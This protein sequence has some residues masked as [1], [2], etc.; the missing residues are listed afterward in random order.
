[1]LLE[2][3]KKYVPKE[4]PEPQDVGTAVDANKQFIP[5]GRR[6]EIRAAVERFLAEHGDRGRA[7]SQLLYD[8]LTAAAAG[9]E[10][11]FFE[12]SRE[13]EPSLKFNAAIDWISNHASKKDWD[14]RKAILADLPTLW[15][16]MMSD[17][18]RICR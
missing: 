18:K 15:N 5:P 12:G 11:G 6:P 8:S 7:A 13:S 14:P 9:M 2:T 3:G 10:E 17:L 16:E 1:M 4:M